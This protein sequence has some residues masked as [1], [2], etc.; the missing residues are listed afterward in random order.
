VFQFAVAHHYRASTGRI[1][2]RIQVGMLAGGVLGPLTFAFLHERHGYAV[3]WSALAA[4][5]ALGAATMAYA[6]YELRDGVQATLTL[7]SQGT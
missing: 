7:Q 2:G 4:A 6:A 3:A 1:S 5:S